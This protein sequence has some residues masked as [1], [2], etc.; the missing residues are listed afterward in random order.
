M[1]KYE[2]EERRRKVATLLAQSMTETEI[3]NE[4]KADHF[5]SQCKQRIGKTFKLIWIGN[6][7]FH[8]EDIDIDIVYKTFGKGEPILLVSDASCGINI[9]S[10]PLYED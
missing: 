10:P 5:I 2:I 3:A 7:K 8:V 9:S 1:H 6:K 4:L